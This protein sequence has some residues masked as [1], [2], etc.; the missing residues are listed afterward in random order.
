MSKYITNS[1]HNDTNDNQNDLNDSEIMVIGKMKQSDTIVK[2]KYDNVYFLDNMGD[3]RT[4]D[5]SE[6]RRV[7][8]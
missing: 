2:F 1:I 5:R 3:Y 7:V 4:T 6:E 8:R